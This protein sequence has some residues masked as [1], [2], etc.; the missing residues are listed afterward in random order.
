MKEPTGAYFMESYI[1]PPGQYKAHISNFETSEHKGNL[2]YNLKYKLHDSITDTQ[3]PLLERN[4]ENGELSAQMNGKKEQLIGGDVFIDVVMRG[5]GIWLTPNAM[6]DEAWKNRNYKKFF[7]SIGVAFP[8]EKVAGIER[9]AVAEVEE[10]DVLGLPVVIT[11]GQV[12]YK[13][14][15]GTIGYTMKVV[16]A[17]EWEDGK[18]L[19]SKELLALMPF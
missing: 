12:E 9:F 17:D 19:T 8:V 5:D 15:N 4:D 10:E 2:V 13:K 7:E 18:P 1:L 6:P 16:W 3:F 11:I 14:K